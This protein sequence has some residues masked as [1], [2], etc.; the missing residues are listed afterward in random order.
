M[1]SVHYLEHLRD[2][3][4]DIAEV[5]RRLAEVDRKVRRATTACRF[6]ELERDRETLFNMLEKLSEEKRRA[7]HHPPAA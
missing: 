6:A 7:R 1:G 3:D 4:F 5:H 2:I